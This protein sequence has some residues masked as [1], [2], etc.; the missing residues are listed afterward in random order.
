MLTFRVNNFSEFIGQDLIKQTL[1][2]MIN[3]AN[4]EKRPIDHLLF[5]GPP[6]LGK[7]TLAN[8]I[9]TETNRNIIYVQGPLL[10][11]RSDLIT[12]FSSINEN[13]IIF[14]DE[15]HSVNK[16][17]YELLY[18]A[19]EEGK[20]DIVLGVDGDKKIMRLQL[21]TF[22]L[23]AATTKFES[24]SQPLKDRFGFIARL[25]NYSLNEIEQIIRNNA[26]KYDINID[27]ESIKTIARNSRLTPRIANNLLKR[28]N[29]FAIY[30]NKT[31]IDINV[32][33][34]TFKFIGI[35]NLGLS[36]LQIEY[37]KI[38]LKIFDNKPA[39]LDA[40]SSILNENKQTIIND[41]ES[42]LIMNKFI[43]KT[44]RGRVIT[45]KGIDYIRQYI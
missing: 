42:H 37:L 12:L 3:A 7:T 44:I 23:I 6:G 22:S 28:S 36:D 15:I 20:I 32:V 38:L 2:V 26:H 34:N 25:K 11:K 45:Q 16:N 10:E 39:S 29:D 1:K 21:K 33:K 5:Y 41:V 27:D 14:I 24:L 13:D 35:F 8:I 31:T 18:S 43:A 40:I 17:L 19:M 4:S 9:A 30:E